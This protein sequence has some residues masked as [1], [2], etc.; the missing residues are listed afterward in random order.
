MR[1]NYIVLLLASTIVL[2]CCKKW[3]DYKKYISAGEKVYPYAATGIKSYPGN[4][5]VLLTW[6][7]GIDTR[8]KTYVITWNNGSDSLVVNAGTYKAGDTVKQFIT[9]LPEA[10]YS[11]TIYSKDVAGNRSV[12]AHVPAVNVYGPKYQ[13][14]LLNRPL[15]SVDYSGSTQLLTVE[16]NA[17]DTINLG[18]QVWYTDAA[19]A[20]KS[21]SFDATQ[22]TI[23]F[24]WQVGSKIYYQSMYKPTSTAIDNFTV[25]N[26]DSITVKYAPVPKT[27]WKKVNLPH[28]IA[29]DAWGTSLSWIWD[30]KAGG[31][32]QIYHSDGSGLPH[33][34]TIDLGALY[35][36]NKVEETGRTDCACHNVT[37]FEVWGIADTTGAATALPADD[38]GWKQESQNKGWILLKEIERTDDGVAPFGMVLPDGLP[39]VRFVRI[40][41]LATRDNSAE[42]HMS[43]LSFWYMP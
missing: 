2:T 19:G 17:P 42:S 38:A 4:Q 9:N 27:A 29:A 31:Y 16:W 6:L 12:P 11:F 24:S 33:H 35:A 40:R 23:S 13:A 43:E 32:P 22:N 28:D 5:R 41:V 15:R 25:V 10:N 3:D 36:L 8:V 14:T 39:A 26:K 18:T 37:K 21:L 30:G 20:A 1:P 34:F 7:H